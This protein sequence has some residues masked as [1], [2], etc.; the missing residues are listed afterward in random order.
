M[1]S[2][3]RKAIFIASTMAIAT[4]MSVGTA[5][6]KETAAQIAKAGLAELASGKVFSKGPNG[7]TPGT[8]DSLVFT[9]AELKTLKALNATAA[10]AMHLSSDWSNGQLSGLKKEF[11]RLGISIV[12]TTQ[13]DFKADVQV[14]QIQTLMAKKPSVL[15][16]I[17]VDSQAMASTYKA[18]A[19]AGTKIVFMGNVASGMTA[20]KDYI[21]SV[22]PDDYANGASAAYLLGKHLNGKGTIATIHHAADFWVTK[23]R[24]NGF[25]ET[26]EKKFKGIKIVADQ[27]ISGPDFAGDAQAAATAILTKYPKIDAIWAVWDTPAEGVLAALRAAGNTKTVI[28]TED[29]GANVAIS[30]A[31]GGPV[32]AVGAQRPF[33]MGVAEARLAAYGLLGKAAPAFVA[34]PGFPVDHNNVLKAWRVVY[35][36]APPA[37]LRAAFNK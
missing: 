8:A 21:S 37:E 5:A 19:D 4:V 13:A 36:A 29:R 22:G 27:G 30:L 33:D 24:W 9:D 26:I 15:V 16:S 34:V 20:G 11:G 32:V 23:A 17:P 10:I 25:K 1:M 7:E 28:A 6:A 3:K 14:S 2:I 12:G 31:K 35:S 18:V